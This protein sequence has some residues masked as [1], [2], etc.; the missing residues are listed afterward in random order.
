MLI[1]CAN[2]TYKIYVMDSEIN[3]DEVSDFL[4]NWFKDDSRVNIS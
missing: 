3:E 1:S 4:N 2:A